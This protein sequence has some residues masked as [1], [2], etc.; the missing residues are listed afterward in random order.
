[1]ALCCGGDSPRGVDPAAV[2]VEF[3]VTPSEPAD[4]PE[5]EPMQPDTAPREDPLP[6][7]ASEIFLA[8]ERFGTSASEIQARLGLPQG[9]VVDT[10]RNVYTTRLDEVWHMTYPGLRFSVYRAEQG[11]LLLSLRVETDRYQFPSGIG[12]GR[13]AFQVRE[14][15]GLP[16]STQA[17]APGTWLWT[18]VVDDWGNQ[19]SFRVV[20]DTV[21]RID[22]EVNVN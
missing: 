2:P 6:D 14:L 4:R 15:L 17:V 12:V 18:Y 13:P 11:D 3:R 7:P 8:M 19:L 5:S 20:T 16:R 1:M 21:R 9:T 10:V 22:W